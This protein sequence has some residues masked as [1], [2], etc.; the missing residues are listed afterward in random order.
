MECNIARLARLLNDLVIAKTPS[1]LANRGY[2]ASA[3]KD[4]LNCL[5]EYGFVRKVDY[6]GATYYHLTG[7]GAKLLELLLEALLERTVESLRKKGVKTKIWWGD[8]KVRAVKPIIYVDREV[9][10][11]TEIKGLIEVKLYGIVSLQKK[12]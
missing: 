1:E 2:D 8:E 11:P 10:V 12:K 5:V 4:E 9:E 6:N 3:L 7:L